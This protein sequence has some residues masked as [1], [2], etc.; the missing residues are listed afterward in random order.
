MSSGRLP[1]LAVVALTLVPLLY[2]ALYLYANWDPYSRMG[3]VRAALV[4]LDAGAA[5]DGGDLHV[6]D[7][8]TGKLLEDGSFGWV[9]VGS[10]AEAEAGVASGDYAF[11]LT[12]PEDFSANLASPEDLADTRQALLSVTTNDANNYMV[13]TFADRLAVTVRD[14]VAAEV[15]TQTADALLAGFGDIH[16]KMLEASDGA[17]ELYAGTVTLS[18]GAAD[19]SSGAAEADAGAQR[20]AEGTRQVNDGAAALADGSAAVDDGAAKARDGA[21]S[22]ATGAGQLSDGAARLS[23]GQAALVDGADALAD[24]TG[25]ASAGAASLADGLATLQDKTEGLPADAKALAVGAKAAAAGTEKLAPGAASVADGTEKLAAALPAQVQAMQD[26][27]AAHVAE[28]VATLVGNGTLTP[29]QASALSAQIDANRQASAADDAKALDGLQSTLDTL[30]TGA[31]SVSNGAAELNEGLPR[32][33]SG[34]RAL[35]DSAPALADGISSAAAGSAALAD[36]AATLDSGAAALAEG[37]RQASAGTSALASGASDLAEGTD[38]LADG[39]ATL[40]SGASDLAS[41]A[42]TLASGTSD[43]S[44]GASTLADGTSTLAEGAQ[45]LA[46]GSGR[47]EDGAGTLSDGLSDGAGEVP[48]LTDGQRGQAAATIGDPVAVGTTE[49]ASAKVYG[50]G[51]AP[52]FLALALWIGVFALAQVMRPIT[53]RALASNASSLKIAIGGWLPFLLLSAAQATVLYAVVLLGLGLDPAH[54][55]MVWG[56]LLL[57]SLAFSAL[58]QGVIAFLG[59]PGKLVVLVL[60]VLQMVSAGGTFPWETAP[61]PLQAAHQWLPMGYIVSGMR[62]LMYGADLAVMGPIVLALLGFTAFGVALSTVAVRRNKTW[63]LKT[64]HPELSS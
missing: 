21:A 24:G 12:I 57:T 14:T 8:V 15:G 51:M 34:T 62:H 49:Q 48:A 33:A 23:A 55:W 64:L 31:R 9:V 1:R 54:P 20:L 35:A 28:A 44:D 52:F 11:A 53:R 58:I 6:G 59:T 43:L 41:G 45:G 61:A 18:D 27:G 30:A 3:E 50:E 56:L 40:S 5:R 47:V 63:T 26:A 22:A 37:A 17:S 38:S 4:N 13:G 32:L 2:G 29:A 60:L 42:G 7:D 19:L 39:A 10:A 36:G 25:R 46:D 16:T